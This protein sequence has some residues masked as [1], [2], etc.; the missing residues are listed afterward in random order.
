MPGGPRPTRAIVWE[1]RSG[2][3]AVT[4]ATKSVGTNTLSDGVRLAFDTGDTV[5]FDLFLARGPGD[6]I[7][8]ERAAA[9]LAAR[10]M[11]GA[12]CQHMEHGALRL[13]PLGKPGP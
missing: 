6:R 10:G 7:R 3:G 8:P 12:H 9:R 13:S 2:T 1:R 4:G 5:G 11:G